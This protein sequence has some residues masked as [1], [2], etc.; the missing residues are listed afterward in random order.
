M[1]D[2]NKEKL[3]LN[4]PCTWKYKVIGSCEKAISLGVKEVVLD[5]EYKLQASNVSKKGKFLS[6]SLELIVHNE[7]DRTTIFD[8][9]GKH[10]SIKMV[11]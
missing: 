11:L 3:E 6:F 9:L 8:L 4:Y 7:D 2:L 5:R 1:I 10:E